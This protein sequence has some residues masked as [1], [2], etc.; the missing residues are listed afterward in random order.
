MI[1]T[2]IMIVIRS[3]KDHGNDDDGENNDSDW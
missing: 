1:M 2:M 3:S